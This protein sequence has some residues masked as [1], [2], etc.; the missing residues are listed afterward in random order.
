MTRPSPYRRHRPLREALAELSY[1][2]GSRLDPEVAAR[3]IGLVQ[4]GELRV[5]G[6]EVRPVQGRAHRI[7]G[8]RS[9]PVC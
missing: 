8:R 4:R 5:Q 7:S 1:C 9:R 6:H 2:A 3:V